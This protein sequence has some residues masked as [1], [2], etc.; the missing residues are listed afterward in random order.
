M[1]ASERVLWLSPRKHVH[2]FPLA[3]MTSLLKCFSRREILPEDVERVL[4]IV[5]K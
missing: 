1:I 5:V 2:V 3:L 4:L